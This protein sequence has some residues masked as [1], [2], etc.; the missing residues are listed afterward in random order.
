MN[1][2]ISI[3]EGN[4]TRILAPIDKLKVNTTDNKDST[5]VSAGKANTGVLHASENGI[6]IASEDGYEAYSEVIV[7]V[8]KDSFEGDTSFDDWDYETPDMDLSNWDPETIEEF[9]NDPEGFD[10]VFNN[11]DEWK[12]IDKPI[13]IKMDNPKIQDTKISGIDPVTG[14]EMEVGLDEDGY[15]TESTLPSS[16]KIVVPPDKHQYVDG[17][18]ILF[19]GMVVK[20]Y[21]ADGELWTDASHSDG[22]I[23]H[24]ELTFP[25][26]TAVL[27]ESEGSIRTL[28][29]DSPIR[30]YS[31]P[32][33]PVI[34]GQYFL[35]HDIYEWEHAIRF[36]GN[37]KCSLYYYS[38]G[39]MIIAASTEP[40]T[41]GF[42]S[43]KKDD[44]EPIITPRYTSGSYTSNGK[45]VYHC[46]VGVGA[47]D[48]PYTYITSKR[49]MDYG[50]VKYIAWEMIYGDVIREGSMEVPVQ[51]IRSDGE[52]L[53][54]SFTIEVL[55]DPDGAHSN[56]DYTHSQVDPSTIEWNHRRYKA[57]EDLGAAEVRNGSVYMEGGAIYDVGAAVRL[58]M[59]EPVD[60]EIVP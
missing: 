14:N 52:V 8:T 42:D 17:Q 33:I 56:P 38:K 35:I 2:I 43:F 59:L 32:P 10:D 5:W 54:D 21:T 26:T 57:N 40:F 46:Y 4:I 29:E 13:D 3:K 16:I 36:W 34:S 18:P 11:E 27:T 51:Y 45:T 44:D 49:S 15:L 39:V 28:P 31:D 30:K 60:N 19:R 47:I 6:Y 58:G 20:A 48:I 24:S 55:P 1:Q 50:D 25:V 12:D 53:E 37:V 22:I 9:E 7:R 23:P 41:Y